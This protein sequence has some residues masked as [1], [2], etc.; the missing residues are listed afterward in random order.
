MTNPQPQPVMAAKIYCQNNGLKKSSLGEFSDDCYYEHI[1]SETNKRHAES[2]QC[3]RCHRRVDLEVI[4]SAKINPGQRLVA[5]LGMIP[6]GFGAVIILLLGYAAFASLLLSKSTRRLFIG[7]TRVITIPYFTLTELLTFLGLLVFLILVTRV[8]FIRTNAYGK[9]VSLGLQ[10]LH[11][12]SPVKVKYIDEEEKTENS[13][14]PYHH[15]VKPR[16]PAMPKTAPVRA[17]LPIPAT[18]KMVTLACRKVLDRE[19]IYSTSA[20]GKVTQTSTKTTYQDRF[21]PI[22]FQIGML[23]ARVFVKQDCPACGTTIL[24]AVDN[25]GIQIA[26]NSDG[27]SLKDKKS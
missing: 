10:V 26:G 16:D 5:L 13:G 11:G 15:S 27:H 25:G 24:F 19:N 20:Y 18:R 17:I 21:A 8:L 1:L 9:S 7:P 14:D 22:E 4:P 23:P 6:Y 3:Q 2:I 12:R